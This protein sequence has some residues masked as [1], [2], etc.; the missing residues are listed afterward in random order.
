[1]SLGAQENAYSLLQCESGA[2][3]DEIRAAYKKLALKLHP[4]RNRN[5]PKAADKFNEIKQALDVLLDPKSRMA[6]DMLI[7]AKKQREERFSKM[8]ETRKLKKS[9]LDAREAAAKK[10]FME[11]RVAKKRKEEELQRL[12][13]EGRKRMRLEEDACDPTRAPAAT[14]PAAAPREKQPEASDPVLL[15]WGKKHKGAI[16]EEQ[17]RNKL[18]VHGEIDTLLLKER[19]AVVTFATAAQRMN[20]MLWLREPCNRSIAGV[21]FEVPNMPEEA[22]NSEGKGIPEPVAAPK[23][24]ANVAS[25]S[26]NLV[27]S[28]GDNLSQ[29]ESIVMMRMRQAAERQRLA[30]QIAQEEVD[31]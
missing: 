28:P 1:M 6:L 30:Q 9:E 31:V 19:S 29:M 5:D 15:K 2:T 4:D 22:N 27:G 16:S 7:N 24:E 21:K 13:Q 25:R 26:E 8:D 10:H 20:A 23:P 17:L 3:E 12:K 11:V 18:S 14:K